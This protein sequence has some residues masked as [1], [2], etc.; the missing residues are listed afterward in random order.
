[1]TVRPKQ[2]K[3]VLNKRN[4]NT[5]EAYRN[6]MKAVDYY[7]NFFN[8]AGSC[9]KMGVKWLDG[10]PAHGLPQNGNK[11]SDRYQ[12]C[13]TRL[14]NFF[15]AVGIPF[16]SFDAC[17]SKHTYYKGVYGNLVYE[18]RQAHHCQCPMPMSRSLSPRTTRNR[19]LYTSAYSMHRSVITL[20]RNSRNG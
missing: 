4:G 11:Y 1:M 8:K 17:F 3:V 20:I 18:S 19:N 14:R 13:A 5:K 15:A 2:A 7:K 16:F 12:I 6:S 9:A 10:S